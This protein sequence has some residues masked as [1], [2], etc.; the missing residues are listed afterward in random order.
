MF[1]TGIDLTYR[2][3]AAELATGA[4]RI[5]EGARRLDLAK[6]ERFDSSALAV[7]L[8]WKRITTSAGEALAIEHVPPG[9]RS[10]AHAYGI[11]TLLFS[12][13]V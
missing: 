3:A 11:D 2:T 10:L 6:L 4:A 12:E 7:L 5:A 9:L 8:E 13:V 1:E